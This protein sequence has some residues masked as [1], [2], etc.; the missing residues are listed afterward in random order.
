MFWWMRRKHRRHGCEGGAHAHAEVHGDFEGFD[1]AQWAQA[2]A[3]DFAGGPFGVRRPLRYLAHKLDLDEAQIAELAKI[4]DE[5]K[6]ERAQAAVDARRTFSAFADAVA[7][8]T[9]AEPRAAEGAGIRV[10]SA[11]RLRD[12][13]VK[14]LG[15]LHAVL[16]PDQRQ[17]L[18]Y[19]IRTGALSL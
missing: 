3:E 1:P 7:G 18:A 9:F 6:T 11:Q 13:V 19:L 17:K 5:L 14:A 15:K 2:F 10:Q 4:L 16:K 8:D 12:A